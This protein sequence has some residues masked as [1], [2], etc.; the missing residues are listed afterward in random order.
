MKRTTILK[1]FVSLFTL[2][3]ILTGCSTTKEIVEPIDPYEQTEPTE[4]GTIILEPYDEILRQLVISGEGE[5]FERSEYTPEDIYTYIFDDTIVFK[6]SENITSEILENGKDPGLGVRKLHQQ[7]ITGKNVNIAIIDQHLLISHPE[8]ADRIVAYYDAGCNKP[9]DQGSYHGATVVGVLGGKTVGVAPEVN[10]YYAAAPSWEFDAK[11]FADSLHWIIDQNKNLPESEK[12]R[13]VSVSSA[14]ESLNDWYKNGELW[15]EAVQA[16]QKDGIMVI[17]CRTDR[18]TS[19]AFPSYWDVDDIDNVEKS[20]PGYPTDRNEDYNRDYYKG[21][22]FAPAS[23]RTFAQELK[24]GEYKYRYEGQ[25]GLSWAVPY[26]AGVLALGWQVNP[27]LDP[28]T[29]K[30]LLFQS[31]WLNKEGVPFINPPAF[32]EAVRQAN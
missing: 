14:P 17:D 7:G 24:E 20:S 25:G 27:K 6:G 3:I 10:I 4:P 23:Y 31:S 12:I 5:V 16:A 30:E 28:A 19:F 13:L 29:M 21:R 2:I 11:Y 32:I 15:E 8:Y 9:E 26:V 22:I 1:I 18:E